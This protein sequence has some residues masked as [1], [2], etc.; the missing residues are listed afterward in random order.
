MFME[1]DT[2]DCSSHTTK[3]VEEDTCKGF[4]SKIYEELLQISKKKVDNSIE[5]WVKSLN[6]QFTSYPNG[7]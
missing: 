5:K 4:V 6:R 1:I 7:Q 2:V 3:R